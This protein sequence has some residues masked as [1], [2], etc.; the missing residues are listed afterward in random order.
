MLVR[1]AEVPNGGG[2]GAERFSV[3]VV[4]LELVHICVRTGLDRLT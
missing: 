4:L 2:V 3:A 1:L